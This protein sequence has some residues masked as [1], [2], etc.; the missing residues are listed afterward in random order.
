MNQ[1]ERIRRNYIL[2]LKQLK[3]FYSSLIEDIKKEDRLDDIIGEAIGEFGADLVRSICEE[4]E[5]DTNKLEKACLKPD[6]LEYKKKAK[7]RLISHYG[8]I[9][10]QI[11]E[12]M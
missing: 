7:N 2:Q 12:M 5:I 8:K 9:V 3:D 10:E 11:D 4:H 6:R 1:I